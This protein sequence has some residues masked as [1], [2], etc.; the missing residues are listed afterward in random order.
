LIGSEK[1][2]LVMDRFMK[3]AVDEAEKGIRKGEGGP[4][5]AVIVRQGKVVAVGHNRV[6]K[7]K[8]P[9]AHAEIVAIRKASAKLKRFDLHDCTLYT[10]C[11]PCP[12]CFSAIHWARIRKVVYGCTRKDA[13]KIGFDDQHF[14][15]II[16]RRAKDEIARQ[17]IDRKEC[18]KAF[19]DWLR[20]S[21]KRMY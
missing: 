20:K 7:T 19:S 2:V 13:A 11:E 12:M 5:G 3:L 17:H 18:M 4:F 21:D 9:T 15:D 1:E 8:D 6:L 16:Q 10:T 14:Y